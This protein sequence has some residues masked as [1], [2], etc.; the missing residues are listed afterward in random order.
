MCVGL[1]LGAKNE[2]VVKD[3]VVYSFVPRLTLPAF[4]CCT[5]EKREEGLVRNVTLYTSSLNERGRVYSN[6]FATR[7]TSVE[8]YYI[9]NRQ[10]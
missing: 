1:T 5:L 7:A 4:Q 8:Q 9:K 10:S 3:Y 2:G 6:R